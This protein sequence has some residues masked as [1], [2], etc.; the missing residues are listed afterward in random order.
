MESYI[1]LIYMYTHYDTFYAQTCY[2]SF[3]NYCKLIKY[4]FQVILDVNVAYLTIS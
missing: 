1:Y 4:T 2:E 3:M